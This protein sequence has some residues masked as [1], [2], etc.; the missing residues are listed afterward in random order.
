MKY[1]ANHTTHAHTFRAT[2]GTIVQNEDR[3]AA[4][5]LAA[6]AE[7][8]LADEAAV[9]LRLAQAV[10]ATETGRAQV[11]MSRVLDAECI[12]QNIPLTPV[13]GSWERARVLLAAVRAD[14]LAAARDVILHI[15]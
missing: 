14:D 5:T 6:L 11:M 7:N 3:E 8:L 12:R 15:G 13:D 2:I 4:A 1:E 9:L 10:L